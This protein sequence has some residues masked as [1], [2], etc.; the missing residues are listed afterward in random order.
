MAETTL[1]P[2][3]EEVD[4]ESFD[5]VKD[6]IEKFDFAKAGALLDIL[7][8]AA[9]IGPMNSAI[10]GL[11]QALLT[12]MNDE[13][14]DIAKARAEAKLKAEAAL[15][16]RQRQERETAEAAAAET[17]EDEDDDHPDHV[18]PRA[19]PNAPTARRV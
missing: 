12:E 11:A 10:V 2:E 8:K 14:R 9:G 6:R 19:I 7:Q 4:Q 16:E 13:A 17:V 15:A 1:T 3:Q 18:R 5:A